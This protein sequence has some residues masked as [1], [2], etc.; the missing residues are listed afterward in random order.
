MFLT[1]FALSPARLYDIISPICFTLFVVCYD[2]AA[3][4]AALFVTA[5][6][7]AYVCMYVCFCMDWYV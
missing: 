5:T 7:G 4:A 6:E 3:T 2:P 1:R